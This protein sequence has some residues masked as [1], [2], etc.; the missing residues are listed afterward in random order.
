MRRAQ[1]VVDSWT[2]A[3]WHEVPHGDWG[4]QGNPPGYPTEYLLG[5][6]TGC[7]QGDPQ[8]D[9]LTLGDCLGNPLGDHLGSSGGQTLTFQRVSGVE[10]TGWRGSGGRIPPL[11]Q[12]VN[13]YTF[14]SAVTNTRH[15]ETAGRL[16][17]RGPKHG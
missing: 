2:R 5:Y 3:L 9:F 13:R 7:T 16:V 4:A 11:S 8:E 1:N 17:K 14:P 6:P 15:L 10:S 12:K